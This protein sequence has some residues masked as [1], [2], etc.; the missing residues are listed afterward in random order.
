I[1]AENSTAARSKL[2][3]QKINVQSLVE[4]V[5]TP[6]GGFFSRVGF[7]ELMT[8]YSAL[9]IAVN[10]GASLREALAAFTEQTVNPKLRYILTDVIRSIEGGKSFSDGL[11]KHDL[12]ANDFVSLVAA[13]EKAGN[14]A[15]M[16]R[17]YVVTAEKQAKIRQK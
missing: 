11:R 13:G 16:F 1:T 14:M 17:D 10:A 3:G 15:E 12:F 5:S 7:Q 8:F 4:E 6:K 2:L 9:S